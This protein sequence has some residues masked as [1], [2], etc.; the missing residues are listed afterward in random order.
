MFLTATRMSIV[1]HHMGTKKISELPT[2]FS[3]TSVN[4]KIFI[5]NL[6]ESIRWKICMYNI[7][8]LHNQGS[9][10]DLKQFNLK[11]R[12]EVANVEIN[13]VQQIVSHVYKMSGMFTLSN[14]FASVDSSKALIRL[15]P[16]QIKIYHLLYASI[17]TSRFQCIH[18]RLLLYLR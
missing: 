16:Q 3:R 6:H 4:I 12:T 10:V 13:E 17:A 14:K 18:F 1:F 15:K 7:F 5:W 2:Y 9:T 11:D 8:K